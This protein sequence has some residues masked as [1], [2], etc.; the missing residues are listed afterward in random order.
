MRSLHGSLARSNTVVALFTLTIIAWSDLV[1]SRIVGIVFDDS[2]SM[3]PHVNLP[4]FGAQ[5][6]ISTLDGRVDKDRL[7]TA[8][9]N[10]KNISRQ[11]DIRT[12]DKH[13]S[14]INTI[15]KNWSTADGNTPYT[16]VDL[17]LRKL[18]EEQKQ[19]EELYFI[20]ISDGQFFN[21]DIELDE[22]HELQDQL[23]AS[24][25][26]MVAAA[27]G[28]VRVDYLLIAPGEKSAE[29]I[30]KI[31]SEGV[32]SRM[33]SAFNGAPKDGSYDVTSFS[34]LLSALKDIIAR[35][36]NTDRSVKGSTVQIKDNTVTLTSPFSV[37]RIITVGASDNEVGPPK[38]VETSFQ[39]VN[40]IDLNSRMQGKDQ[41]A[42][43]DRVFSG[44]TTH[45]PLQPALA[46]GTHS[47]VYDRLIGDEIFL[48]FE[49]DATIRLIITDIS[50]N[51]VNKDA[52]GNYILTLGGDYKFQAKVYSSI[53]GMAEPV[54]FSSLA[55][56]SGFSTIVTSPRNA[57]SNFSLKRDEANSFAFVDFVPTELGLHSAK[58]S[59]RLPGFVSPASLPIT[60]EVKNFNADLDIVIDPTLEDNGLAIHTVTGSP[61][62]E[63]I[64]TA[65]IQTSGL[66]ESGEIEL[67]LQQEDNIYFLGNSNGISLSAAD[68]SITD[69]EPIEVHI[70]AKSSWKPR[71][72]T[73][74]LGR[75]MTLVSKMLPPHLGEQSASFIIKATIPEAQIVPTDHVQDQSGEIPLFISGENLTSN[76]DES[77]RGLVG[78]I[79]FN[80]Y[81]SNNIH[82]AAAENF[83]V[84]GG[85][86][87]LVDWS[88]GYS[89]N[90]INVAP[91]SIF[92]CHCFL[93]L[94]NG[95]HPVEINFTG[96]QG[97]QTASSFGDMSLLVQIS[98]KERNLS[99]LWNLLMMLLVIYLI[100]WIITCIKT[101]RFP[102]HSGLKIQ[103]DNEI[104][105]YLDLRGTNLTLLKSLLWIFR[106]A[107]HEVARLEGLALKA[108]SGGATLLIAESDPQTQPDSLGETLV[109]YLEYHQSQTELRVGWYE[110]F[111]R[112]NDKHR[113]MILLKNINEQA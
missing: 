101:Q 65:R 21:P 40:Q 57:L 95:K 107:P 77:K 47:I 110:T 61:D 108:R 66:N 39:S 28:P 86:S 32:R 52:A 89:D 69:G 49:T 38:P 48:L 13:Q 62:A 9:L 76:K 103:K 15:R 74:L 16:N 87:F 29:N 24:Y 106:G 23:A 45:F 67:E 42:G 91:N 19:G 71:S 85:P 4:A 82:P 88:V 112:K 54:E 64:A 75:K 3:A 84:S 27:K 56:D 17:M 41:H 104:P 58:G 55:T 11:Q 26:Q 73:D 31:E 53:G 70:W 60:Y 37:S 1:H 10:Q 92:W 93:W 90:S 105:R 79:G 80:Y 59:L 18:I 20:L 2:G 72:K 96:A 100:G 7:F 102:A 35:V 83:S 51:E 81:L 46:P 44:L 25:R 8:S 109:E 33:L 12:R 113:I 99:C 50:G 78:S 34:T 97:L 43:W 14:L 63:L 98:S 22:L 94:F 5:L 6:L 30:Q 68:L 36:S 111:S